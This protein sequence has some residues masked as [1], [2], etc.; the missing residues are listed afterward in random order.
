M[1]H[2]HFHAI[3]AEPQSKGLVMV[4]LGEHDAD[5]QRI[6]GRQTE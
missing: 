2:A 5:I 6:N 3:V 1:F 4:A